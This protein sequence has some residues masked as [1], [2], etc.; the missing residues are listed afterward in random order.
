MKD[1]AVVYGVGLWIVLW[2]AVILTLA[3]VMLAGQSPMPGAGKV[4]R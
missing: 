2:F 4:L 1:R 3:V